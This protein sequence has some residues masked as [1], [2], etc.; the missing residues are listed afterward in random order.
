MDDA[1]RNGLWNAATLTLW[2]RLRNAVD[3]QGTTGGNVFFKRLWLFHYKQPLDRMP[4]DDQQR[5]EDLRLRFFHWPWYEVYDFIEFAAQQF[6]LDVKSFV[7]N[8]N[9]V[10][11]LEL[12]AYRFV[13]KTLTPITSEQELASVREAIELPEP[14]K[15]AR[16][17]LETSVQL[18][19]N[20]QA[21]DYRNS[22]KGINQCR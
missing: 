16:K 11:E 14:F 18:F 19:S 4:W 6:P 15:A 13:G 21:P 1:L 17:H 2:D 8:C 7:S 22:I 12:S 10:F 9:S 3:S 5:L 20:R